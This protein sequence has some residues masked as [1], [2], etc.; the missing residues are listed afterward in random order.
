[1]LHASLV[2]AERQWFLPA[3]AA[4]VL[5][6]LLLAWSYRT[7]PPG[8][9]RRTCLLLKAAGIAALAFCLLEPLWSGQRARPGA[10]LFA[11]VADNSQGLQIR[12]AGAAR[13]RGE[14]LRELLDPGRSAWPD[15]LAANFGVRRYR[16]D[17]RLQAVPDFS[18]LV[19]DG[20]SSAIGA[21]LRAIGERNR[22]RPLAGVLLLTDGNATDLRA[23][24]P[25]LTGLP[26][27]YPVVLGS[28][29]S[30]QDLSVQEVRTSQ[31]AFEDAP[32]TVE[33]DVAVT[34][35]EGRDVVARLFDAAGAS[36]DEQTR[37]VG[38]S[39]DPLTFRFRPRP[40]GSGLAFYR[41]AVAPAGSADSGAA[42]ATMA[43]NS[44]VVVV[45][46]GRGPH[47]ILY[48]TGRPNWEFKFLNRALQEDPQLQ[49]VGLIRVARREPKFDFRGRAGET[50]FLEGGER[51][52]RGAALVGLDAAV[53]LA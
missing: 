27:V 18:E 28:R 10:N 26:P 40:E 39:G 43:N 1:M 53:G 52:G 46:R 37:R 3:A 42:E 5:A 35:F 33:A 16:F 32:V 14:G 50:R 31:T 17:S 36:V 48:V 49:L 19:F 41:L 12:D 7:T 45:D 9:V 8:W 20:R 34:G 21:A 29:D 44:R 38:A 4:A 22:G 47:R 51:V 11:V 23:A 15:A 25:D 6:L 30:L 24:L 13:S 2:F